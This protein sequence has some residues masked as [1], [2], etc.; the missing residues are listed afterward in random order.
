MNRLHSKLLYVLRDNQRSSNIY[1]IVLMWSSDE[2]VSPLNSIVKSTGIYTRHLH[3]FLATR[4]VGNSTRMKRT[5][6]YL[7]LAPL[8]QSGDE[9]GNRYSRQ[10]IDASYQVENNFAKQI[11]RILK[12]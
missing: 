6:K 1:I 2:C 5:F 3:L 8:K 12:S 4:L 10:S 7:V 11:Q 9:M